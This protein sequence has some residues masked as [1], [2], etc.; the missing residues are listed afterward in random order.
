MRLKVLTVSGKPPGW[1]NS[2]WDQY[3]K[4]MP[5]HLLLELVTISPVHRYSESDIPV[6]QQKETE[7]LLQHTQHCHRIALDGGGQRWTTQ[8][9]ADR[10]KH[11]Q[12]LGQDCAFLIGGADG[13]NQALLQQSQER[14]SLGALTYPH[15]LVRVLLAEQLYRACLLYTSPS[16][17]DQRGSRMP[18]SA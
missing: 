11:W 10:L 3:A 7:K 9:L 14:W 6:A 16:P 8:Q 2:G 18:S 12:Q 15:H 4:R 17:R 1:I 13:H 5:K